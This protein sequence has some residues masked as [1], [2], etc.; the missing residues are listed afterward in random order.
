M[1]Y[2][3]RYHGEYSGSHW[4]GKGLTYTY[5][6]LS[7]SRGSISAPYAQVDLTWNDVA[8]R[9]TSLIQQGK[10]LS[11]EDQAAIPAFERNQIARAVYTFFSHVS[12]DTSTAIPQKF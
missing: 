6:S 1:T 2:L 11:D 5:K 10:F 9:I 7:F 8:K 3:K 12:E 4:D